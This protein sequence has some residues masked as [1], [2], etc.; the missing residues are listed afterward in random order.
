MLTYSG[1]GCGG[2]SNGNLRVQINEERLIPFFLPPQICYKID[3][4]LED[5]NVSFLL[6]LFLC[7][8]FQCRS[9]MNSSNEPLFLGLLNYGQ[10]YPRQLQP[11]EGQRVQPLQPKT[12][13]LAMT[14]W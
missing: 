4:K 10:W 6:L 13:P 5:V 3:Y 2:I 11:L 8:V 9:L 7:S 1:I 12:K 14:R